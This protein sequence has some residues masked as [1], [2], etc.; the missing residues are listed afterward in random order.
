MGREMNWRGSVKGNERKR[1]LDVRA[2]Q[3]RR[4]VR[5]TPECFPVYAVFFPKFVEGILLERR[6][7]T[8]EDVKD[9]VLLGSLLTKGTGGRKGAN[10]TPRKTTWG[11][12]SFEAYLHGLNLHP[13]AKVPS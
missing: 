5:Y 1:S 11:V 4:Q 2:W 9:V 13:S 10:E 12:R 7:D 6:L 3:I 8:V